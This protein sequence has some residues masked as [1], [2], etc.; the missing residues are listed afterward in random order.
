MITI[1]R[2]QVGETDLFKQVRLT[3]LQD[4]PYA[5][6]T[7]YDAALQRSDESWR[8]Q[9]ERTAK[10]TDRATFIAFADDVPIG[11][12]ALYRLEDKPDVGELLQ[13]WISP[14]HR[15]TRVAWVLMDAIFKWAGENNFRTII[16]GVTKG[17]ARAVKFYIKYGFSIHEES[18]KGVYLVKEVKEG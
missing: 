5:F 18:A 17:N 4:A 16:A 6:P 15:G 14:E 13:V 1:R 2:L 11:M 10:G 9:A 12:T 3:A 8:E 7:T